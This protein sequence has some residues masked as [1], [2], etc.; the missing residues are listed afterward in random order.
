MD[1]VYKIILKPWSLTGQIE[2]CMKFEVSLSQKS[3]HF[4]PWTLP[5]ADSDSA[6]GNRG[7]KTN[8]SVNIS[9][10]RFT[11]KTKILRRKNLNKA[12]YPK[13]EK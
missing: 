1:F 10:Y 13:T 8:P 2:K 12:K 6:L 11:A 3:K 9:F 7:R 5:E 4:Q